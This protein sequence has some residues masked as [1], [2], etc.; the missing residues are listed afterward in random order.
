LENC[1]ERG[2][3]VSLRAKVE[4]EKNTFISHALPRQEKQKSG[5]P[6]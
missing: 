6:G 5:G 4:R 3:T 2:V 1:A